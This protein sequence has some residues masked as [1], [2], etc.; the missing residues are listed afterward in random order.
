MWA[1][2]ELHCFPFKVFKVNSV[3]IAFAGTA[4]ADKRAHGQADA[5]AHLLLCLG[6]VSLGQP[7]CERA[8]ACALAVIM[9][10]LLA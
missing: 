1:F 5:P 8:T 4:G 3:Y 6:F 2:P 9:L 7:V 10:R